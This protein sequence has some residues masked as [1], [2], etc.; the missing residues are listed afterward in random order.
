MVYI[1]SSRNT[2]QVVIEQA[3]VIKKNVVAN[4]IINYTKLTPIEGGC[5]WIS[6][7]CLDISGSI[8][9]MLKRKGKDRMARNAM[10]MIK[11]IKDGST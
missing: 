5:D 9:D 3:S 2:E 8:P 1:A 4:N 7:Q 6:V 11:L 10:M